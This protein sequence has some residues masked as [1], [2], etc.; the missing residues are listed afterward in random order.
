MYY[1]INYKIQREET[2]WN[3]DRGAV[4]IC[5][6]FINYQRDPIFLLYTF[7][8]YISESAKSVD[9]AMLL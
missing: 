4:A 2:T 3:G 6:S 1:I 9:H 5:E 7:T 8:E